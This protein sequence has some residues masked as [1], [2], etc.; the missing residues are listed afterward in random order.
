[1][2]QITK[3]FAL[4]IVML[5]FTATSFAQVIE[6]ATASATIVAPLTITNTIPLNFGNLA[7]DATGG[8]VTLTAV[9]STVRSAGSANVQLVSGVTPTS[10]DFAITGLT[11]STYT[12]AL[13]ADGVVTLTGAGTPMNVNSFTCSISPLTAGSLATGSETFYVGATLSVNGG[14]TPGTYAGTFDVSVIYN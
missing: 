5:A 12:I 6:T 4:A 14:Q 11:G 9:S 8:T 3:F 2:K 7:V 13:P 10:A 1:M